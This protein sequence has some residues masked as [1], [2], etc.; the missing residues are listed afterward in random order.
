MDA[1]ERMAL[2]ANHENATDSLESKLAVLRAMAADCLAHAAE[3]QVNNALSILTETANK[4]LS[5]A[6][7]RAIDTTTPFGVGKEVRDEAEYVSIL[8]GDAS[9]A[10]RIAS[11]SLLQAASDIADECFQYGDENSIE[12]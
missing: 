10:M 7:A 6:E 3:A 8:I 4:F 11:E 9:K 2:I 1:E 5:I 12:H